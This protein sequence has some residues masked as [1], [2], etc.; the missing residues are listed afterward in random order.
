M[1][2]LVYIKTFGCQMNEYD[3]S[4]MQDVLEAAHGMT[5]TEDPG[6]G[7]PAAGQYLL[8][9]GKGAGKS[10]FPAGRMAALQATA[11]AGG[12]RRRR[13]RRQSGGRGD[14]RARAVRRFGVRPANSASPAG[15]ARGSEAIGSAANRRQ[16]P[17]DREVRSS[18][19]GP[20]GRARRPSCPS[21]RAAASTA[22]S[23]SC[24]TRAARKSAGRSSRC[25]REVETLARPGRARSDPARA[26]RQRLRGPDGG[27]HARGF[28]DADPLRR[29]RRRASS[30][31][32]SPPRIRWISTTV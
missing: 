18:A 17:G 2:G 24:R 14:H 8:G 25:W 32:A 15:D 27:R 21:W 7:R 5:R 3:S 9:A 29:G 26:K 30:A 1:S 16:L 11:A 10:V 22:P 31:S 19:R 4:K 13:L 6:G 12:H 28:G 20:C 23:V